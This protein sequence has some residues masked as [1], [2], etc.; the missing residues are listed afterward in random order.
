MAYLIDGH[1]LIPKI[2]GFNLKQVDDEMRLVK[3]LQD[4]CQIRRKNIDVYFDGAPAGQARKQRF[5]MV[6]AHFIRK[7]MQADTAIIQRIRKLNREAQNW[8]VVTSDHRIQSEA[9]VRKAQ[10]VSSEEFAAQVIE[11]L[12]ERGAKGGNEDHQLL[13]EGEIEEWM[14]LFGENKTKNS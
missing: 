8:I 4:F 9:R 12:S 10:V 11:T 2:P 14:R 6:T 7:E 1:N 5:G 3:L 13:S